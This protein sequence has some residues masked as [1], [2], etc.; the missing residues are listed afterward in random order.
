M[1]S[2]KPAATRI[3]GQSVGPGRHLL[4]SI[5]EAAEMLSVCRTSIYELIWKD[6]LTAVHIGRSVRLAVEQLERFVSDRVALGGT[7]QAANLTQT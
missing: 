7:E 3:E 2:S 5:P 6:E 1:T 4:V